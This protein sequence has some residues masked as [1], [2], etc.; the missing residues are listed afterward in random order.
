MDTEVSMHSRFVVFRIEILG[1]AGSAPDHA[2]LSNPYKASVA[3]QWF[4]MR[5]SGSL[6]LAWR[7]R[8]LAVWLPCSASNQGLHGWLSY[9]SE[10][11][12]TP[13]TSP[14]MWK[15]ATGTMQSSLCC[16]LCVGK[17]LWC[18][19]QGVQVSNLSLNWIYLVFRPK[20]SK[21][22]AASTV[23]QRSFAEL[24][25]TCF[26]G[27]TLLHQI[28]TPALAEQISSLNA[29]DL[30]NLEL[31]IHIIFELNCGKAPGSFDKGFRRMN[32]AKRV[33]AA[34][35]N[36]KGEKSPLDDGHAGRGDEHAPADCFI[37]DERFP[38]G[39]NLGVTV[40]VVF[41]SCSLLF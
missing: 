29:Y 16:V 8:S 21:T 7:W 10:G 28:E 18:R 5:I 34:V 20:I 35:M 9:R 22:A 4:S 14:K 3:G 26:Q 19:M 37:T 17:R 40:A 23:M 24:H 30:Q 12:I 13:T 11:H 2:N 1:K 38:K 36:D 41:L 6:L 31:F 39:G 33:N 32:S 27:A 15:N 25:R